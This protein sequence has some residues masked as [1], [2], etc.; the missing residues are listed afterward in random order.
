MPTIH[1]STSLTILALFSFFGLVHLFYQLFFFT[2]AFT[3]KGKGSK[4]RQ[5]PF[6]SVIVCARNE[7]DNLRKLIP[8]LLE[9]DYPHF[10]VIIVDDRS[11]D[12][13]YDYLLEI[14]GL[15]ENL[16]VVRIHFTPEGMNPKKYA[17]TIG[18]RAARGEHLLFTDADCMPASTHWISAMMAEFGQDDEIVLGYAPYEKQP[19]LLNLL[20]RYDTFYTAV[21]YFSFALAGLPYMGV[22]RNL[23]YRKSLFMKLKGF[24]K[25][26]QVTGGDDDLFVNRAAHAGNVSVCTTAD[27]YTYSIPKATWPEWY[28]QKLRHYHAGK[29]YK[30]ID[31][32]NLGLLHGSNLAFYVAGFILS[33]QPSGWLVTAT[34]LGV[35]WVVQTIIFYKIKQTI[36]ERLPVLALPVLDV[37][38]TFIA[39]VFSASALFAR[40]VEW[41]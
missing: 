28:K 4:S 8:R 13:Q 7:L 37:A 31:K 41:R 19:T 30:S 34:G 10:E 20:I 36:K 33:L 27:A 22:G 15:Y 26:I 29:Y 25:H 23:A 21:Q 1:S 11:D 2:R 17:L 14:K 18:I 3:F 38:H 12:I 6:V 32:L 16:R 40:R 39:F 35:K 5:Q 9:Q 24:Y